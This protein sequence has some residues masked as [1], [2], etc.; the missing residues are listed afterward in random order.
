MAAD[1]VYP[2]KPFQTPQSLASKRTKKSFPEH[3]LSRIQ[4]GCRDFVVWLCGVGSQGKARHPQ[5]PPLNP[6]LPWR[7]RAESESCSEQRALCIEV[8]GAQQL[9]CSTLW[10]GRVNR[11]PTGGRKL[12]DVGGPAQPGCCHPSCQIPLA[13][14]NTTSSRAQDGGGD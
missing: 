3:F 7:V 13:V 14:E 11:I 4:M 6:T 1:G 12:R 10:C 8:P 2:V 5:P 9:R